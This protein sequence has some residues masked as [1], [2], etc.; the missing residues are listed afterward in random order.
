MDEM[1]D[2]ARD[3]MQPEEPTRRE[4]IRRR[5]QIAGASFA[6]F[7]STRVLVGHKARV[8]RLTGEVFTAER[9]GGGWMYL[10]FGPG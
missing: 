8:R 6:H 3:E 9:P 4:F 2:M 10:L 7:C 5:G 1:D